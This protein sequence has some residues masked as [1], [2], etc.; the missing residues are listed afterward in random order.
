G[1][2]W[3]Q[4]T[5]AQ[6]A[7]AAVHTGNL[8]WTGPAVVAASNVLFAGRNSSGHVRMYA[9]NPLESGSSVSHWDT[10]LAPDELLEPFATPYPSD[11]LTTHLLNDI[12]WSLQ[13]TACLEGSDTACVQV[14]RFEVKVDWQSATANGSGHVMGFAG[15]RAESDESVFWWFF[16]PTNF[17]MGVKV[18]NACP[19]NGKF[20]VYLSGLTDQGWT[21][22][23]RD[24]ATGAT[25][26]YS[27]PLGHLSS[28]FADTGAFSCP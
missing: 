7:A 15:P 22:H 14:G 11:I 16:S 23:I 18:L 8:H 24:T 10:A 25:Q 27:N 2:K 3:P 12:G 21:V 9:P 19:V 1:K 26:T 17:E 20:W 5:S 4:M 6:R 28:T 13:P